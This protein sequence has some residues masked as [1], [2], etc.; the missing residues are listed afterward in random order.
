MLRRLLLIE[1]AAFAK[2]N[3][4]P[5]LRVARKRAGKLMHFTAEAPEKW[6]V[7]FHCFTDR[8]RT[9]AKPASAA[10]SPPQIERPIRPF[11]FRE[12]RSIGAKTENRAQRRRAKR[13]R[14]TPILRQDREWI[15]HQ[16]PLAFRSAWPLAERYEALRRVIEAPLAY[17]RRL[18]RLLHATPHRARAMLRAPD[19]ARQRVDDFTELGAAAET[20]AAF[21]NSS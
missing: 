6:R 19:E 10:P 14:A 12:E 4:R 9:A 18:A 11:I 1:A 13:T 2:P 7:S 21:F 8:R 17:A 15:K 20:S 16:P 5:L 3:T